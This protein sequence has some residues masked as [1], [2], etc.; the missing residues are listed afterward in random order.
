[1]KKDLTK[2]F[3][4]LSIKNVY[5][6]YINGLKRKPIT[7][8]KEEN[9][10]DRGK[11][12]EE[13]LFTFFSTNLNAFKNKSKTKQDHSFLYCINGSGFGKTWFGKRIPIYLQNWC[14]INNLNY[15]VDYLY[16]DFSNGSRWRDETRISSDIN[17]QFSLRLLHLLTESRD[18]E[19]LET[20][21]ALKYGKQTEIFF[22]EVMKYYS[23][24]KVLR[25]KTIISE[26]LLLI[27]HF[28]E[29]QFNP[30][31]AQ[32][33]LHVIADYM[34]SS[35]V[36][37]NSIIDNIVLFPVITG[38]SSFG[39]KQKVTNYSSEYIDL[40]PFTFQESISFLEKRSTN[41]I[42][43]QFFKY[44]IDSCGGVP[45][46]LEC[47]SI[48][49][50]EAYKFFER[51]DDY[52][53]FSPNLNWQSTVSKEITKLFIKEIKARYKTQDW[54]STLKELGGD[55]APQTILSLALLGTSIDK[56]KKLS[57]FNEKNNPISL[58]ELQTTGIFYLNSVKN[59]FHKYQVFLPLISVDLMNKSI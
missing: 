58:E 37:S 19:I 21:I 7:I 22:S 40:P 27:F 50:N 48:A 31:N 51:E 30:N 49:S 6:E 9:F 5:E 42:E 55:F 57:D 16:F 26:P 45:R 46:F 3:P 4:N 44:L 14:K 43:E 54:I 36:D 38:T 11:E 56:N 2:K 17:T 20:E 25:E 35:N 12:V 10:I 41:Y 1:M 13:N 8:R 39:F 28:D 24:S 59:Q 34:C 33:L 52:N 32:Y 29:L 47:L 53:L 18:L 15:Q 23:N